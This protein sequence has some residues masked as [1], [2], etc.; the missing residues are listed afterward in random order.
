MYKLKV[1]QNKQSDYLI[2]ERKIVFVL[3]MTT[4]GMMGAYT[5]TVRGGV[6]CNAQTANFA[7]MAIAIGK[8]KIHQAVY[9]VIP[10]LAYLFGCVISEIL[11]NPVKRI[12]LFR[13]DTYLIG[14]EF[15][16]LCFIGFI[17]DTISHHYVQVTINF[18]CAMQ[19][20][21]FR[22]AEGISMATTFCT[23]HVRQTAVGAVKF[24]KKRDKE[25]LRRALGHGIMILGFLLGGITETAL[26][27][28]IGVRAIWLALVPLTI[29]LILFVYADL[30][31]EKELLEKV[32]RGH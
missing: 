27:M 24:I 13:W 28:K 26:C 15:L 12:K 9:Y 30:I 25:S 14:F 32:P 16:V 31:E 7:M 4:A 1:L 8:G 19:Y 21:T 6:F 18:L 22:Q 3:L 20:N 11:P 10:A 17:P 5:L 23:N 29:I 2:C